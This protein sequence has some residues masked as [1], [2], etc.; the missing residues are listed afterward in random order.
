MV[1][2]LSGRKTSQLS[3]PEVKIVEASAGSGKTYELAK[4][5]VQ[6]LFAAK[7]QNNKKLIAMRNILAIT[8]THKATR[9]MKERI[10]EQLKK[11]ALGRFENELEKQDLLGI[12]NTS[13]ENAQK[14]AF[15]LI[16]DIIYNYNFFQ[17]KNIDSFINVIL[18]GCASEL[19]LSANFQIK[20]NYSESISYALDECIDHSRDNGKTR[21]MFE[22][23]L[24]QYLYLE[25]RSGWFPK[26]DIFD[27]IEGIFLQSNIYGGMFD[28]FSAE[29]SEILG[30]KHKIISILKDIYDLQEPGLNKRFL[31][32]TLFNFLA[33][34]P[35]G[36]NISELDK[37]TFLKDDPPLN[38]GF[39]PS[40]ELAGLWK[41]FR[42][43][44]TEL[45]EREALS[46][47]NCYID[48]FDAVYSRFVQN[49][50]K[51]DIVFMEELNR[52][53]YLLFEQ[54]SLSIP[55]LYYRLA[56]RLN[57]FLIDEFQDTSKL[58]WV[59]LFSMIENA[60]SSGG[61]LFYVGD[62]KQAIYRFRGGNVDL[63][64]QIKRDFQHFN[65][66]DKT[67]LRT[68]YRSHK[69][70]IE[71]N[72]TVFSLDN[73][74]R[75][76]NQQ[77]SFE[78]NELRHFSSNEI[79]KIL[80]IFEDSQQK[81]RPEKP[82]GYVNVD[83]LEYKNIDD[84]Q[85]KI[86]QH[87]IEKV[88]V[89][90]KRFPLKSI[91][92]LCR[93]NNE[94]ELVTGWLS[95]EKLNVES[96]RTLNIL[97]NSFIREILA[98]LK[99]L[100]SPIDSIEF[101]G[102]VLGDIFLNIS[103]LSREKVADFIFE[104]NK[105]SNGQGNIY[106][107]FREMFPEIWDE[108]IADFFKSAGFVSVY[109]L[110]ISIFEKFRIFQGFG[111]YQGF[112][113]RFLEIIKE[114][115]DENS[116]VGSFLKYLQKVPESKLYV[117][118]SDEN[119]IKVMTIHKAKGLGFA[120]V[121]VPFLDINIR[122]LGAKIHRIKAP[123]I[124]YEGYSSEQEKNSY[125]LLRL[126]TKY[127]KFSDKIRKIYKQ[128]YLRS[129][130]DELNTV[131]VTFTRAQNELYVFIPYSTSKSTASNNAAYFL[132]PSKI[133]EMGN[134]EDYEINNSPD[135]FNLK[136]S[137]PV[138]K[139]WV[140]ALKEEFET[141]INTPDKDRIYRGILLHKMLSEIRNLNG[142]DLQNLLGI[143]RDKYS[144]QLDFQEDGFD[145]IKRLKQIVTSSETR[146][147]FF[148]DK[149]TKVF[150]EK[151]FVDNQG[152]TKRLDR[153][154]LDGN[155]AIIIDFKSSQENKLRSLDQLKDYKKLLGSLYRDKKIQ[156]Y[157]LFMDTLNVEQ[158]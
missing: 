113:M 106:S 48:I 28:K 13:E 85:A 12:C 34:N 130:I 45:S 3:F 121:V 68:N 123:Y 143:I 75:F 25:N 91:A 117:N 29:S 70:I 149:N 154:I 16:N 82:L 46:L 44:I 141:P 144:K 47:F 92:V 66:N 60:L 157:L 96:E 90:I 58:Q 108:Y 128:E 78:S 118:F 10:L 103:G 98:F 1:M 24:R 37:K 93:S 61:S 152:N 129:F 126:D 67:V 132:L 74:T 38:K 88:Q 72:N 124:V 112:F 51:D 43:L 76:L 119:A 31:N 156:A 140:S 20:E 6:L 40:P 150:L 84:K 151:Q 137:L 18:S 54:T 52:K 133:R 153:V 136:I 114:Y 89:L 22:D 56:C 69:K 79:K 33:N 77:K 131:Y 100:N 7:S 81:D 101:A 41:Q 134:K 102:F 142:I 19:D 83:Y 62:K 30:L 99:F 94:I 32:S 116:S 86:K 4:R 55:E 155:K 73:L 42:A 127:A 15:E 11:I 158:I 26:K 57:H 107:V 35:Q 64:D 104:F 138:Y 122:E 87:L 2:K 109:E 59:N 115:E 63:F 39:T 50:K 17:V 23:F 110:T 139:N 49:A 5:Y 97:N 27:I 8:F 9:E 21:K 135:N 65:V 111:R 145:Y 80:E 146:D 125:G 14:I 36:F 53:A 95:E 71:F 147:F 105:N 120:V 148:L